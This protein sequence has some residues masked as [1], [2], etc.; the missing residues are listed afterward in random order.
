MIHRGTSW[1]RGHP[2]NGISRSQ[3]SPVLKMLPPAS[4]YIPLIWL[5]LH[6]KNIILG[7]L[8]HSFLTCQSFICY[9]EMNNSE[10]YIQSM[11]Q[12]QNSIAFSKIT[13]LENSPNPSLVLT[14][15]LLIQCTLVIV[16][17]FWP[18]KNALTNLHYPFANHI[19]LEI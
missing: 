7:C 17:A 6:I 12:P 16:N 8:K 2:Q 5:I 1:E 3:A 10:R 14:H 18:Y 11:G 4:I 9:H 13:P 19:L 15:I